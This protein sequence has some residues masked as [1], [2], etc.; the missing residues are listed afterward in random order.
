MCSLMNNSNMYVLLLF[1]SIIRATPL[2]PTLILHIV[3]VTA[4][5]GKVSW[6][7]GTKE[8]HVVTPNSKPH[9]RDVLGKPQK[10]SR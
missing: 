6:Q 4:L 8:Y 1:K 2:S 9:S 5:R 3:S 7:S 10:G